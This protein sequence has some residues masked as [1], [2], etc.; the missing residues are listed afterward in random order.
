M[1]ER[2]EKWAGPWGEKYLHF[3]A[4]SSQRVEGI[5]AVLKQA[6]V[7]IAGLRKQFSKIDQWMTKKVGFVTLLY[8]VKFCLT[9]FML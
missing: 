8:Q 6:L 9:S 5:H 7:N 2:K 4:R 1:L 3:G